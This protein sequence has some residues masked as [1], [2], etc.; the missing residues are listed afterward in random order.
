MVADDHPM[1]REAAK[2][3]LRIADPDLFLVEAATLRDTLDDRMPLDLVIL[4]LRLP[5]SNGIGS[6]IDVMRARPGTSI[7]VVSATEDADTER[8]VAALGGSG[9]VS[10]AA[11]ITE[12]VE[13][14]RAILAGRRWFGP[15]ATVQAPEGTDRASRLAA[16]T[17]AESRVLRAMSDGRLNKQ[18][19]FDLGLSE[20]TVKQHVKA[21]LRKLDVFNRTQAVLLFHGTAG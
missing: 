10:K 21:I 19:A 18:I 1:C 12:L 15:G 9:F 16:L 8:Q 2:H 5:D 17:A 6:L 11:P 14:V 3:A 20:I 13:A 7:L 4:D